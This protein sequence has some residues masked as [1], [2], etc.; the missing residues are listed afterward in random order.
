[1][2]KIVIFIS[3]IAFCAF[4]G[5]IYYRF[6][7][8]DKS[9][10]VSN[11]NENYIIALDL[12]DMKQIKSR[13]K[14]SDIMNIRDIKTIVNYPESMSTTELAHCFFMAGVIG[15]EFINNESYRFSMIEVLLSMLESNYHYLPFGINDDFLNGKFKDEY[16]CRQ[17][18]NFKLHFTNTILKNSCKNEIL[19]VIMK[20]INDIINKNKRELIKKDTNNLF[21]YENLCKKVLDHKGPKWIKEGRK[22]IKHL[23]PINL[24]EKDKEMLKKPTEEL[25]NSFKGSE[26]VIFEG[27]KLSEK[28][29]LKQEKILEELN[30]IA[31]KVGYYVIIPIIIRA[32]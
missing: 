10:D 17:Y 20:D 32:E 27:E 1:M 15:T 11:E 30:E 3:S 2:K 8:N 19:E 18:N 5:G 24:M 31:I 28:S 4:V 22:I 25:K 26:R 29:M 13:F 14:E 12:K 7:F 6:F 21:V 23:I 9:P 16:N